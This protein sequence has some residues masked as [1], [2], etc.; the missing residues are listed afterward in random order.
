MKVFAVDDSRMILNIYRKVL[1]NIGC[2]PA[3]FE[4]PA[5]AIQQV[6]SNRQDLIFTDLNMPEISGVDLTRVVRQWFNKAQLPIIMVTT[7]NESQD[8][9]AAQAAGVNAIL[10]KPFTEAVL[11][12]ALERYLPKN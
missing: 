8:H 11:R 2:D 10:H 5:E 3:L 6:Q 9:E 4:F 1:H 12:G 7:K